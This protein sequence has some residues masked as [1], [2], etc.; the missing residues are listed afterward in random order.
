MGFGYTYIKSN[1]GQVIK[2]LI[3]LL[4]IFSFRTL[5]VKEEFVFTRDLKKNLK[6]MEHCRPISKLD[7]A[8]NKLC[9]ERQAQGFHLC[10]S[11]G[12]PYY[13]YVFSTKRDCEVALDA[14][15]KYSLEIKQTTR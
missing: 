3:F 10:S 14:F 12:T 5:A 6:D 15:R 9:G 1:Q 13:L 4:L 11:S 7:W 8:I 2:K